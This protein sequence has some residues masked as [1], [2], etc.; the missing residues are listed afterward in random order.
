MKIGNPDPPELVMPTR[1]KKNSQKFELIWKNKP[2]D[3]VN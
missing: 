2:W 3:S 1:F